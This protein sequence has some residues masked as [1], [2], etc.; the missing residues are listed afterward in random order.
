MKMLSKQK[1]TKPQEK[2]KH[3]HGQKK[4]CNTPL[5]TENFKV[6]QI[7]KNLFHLRKRGTDIIIWFN[8]IDLH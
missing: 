8:I 6:K 2:K 3:G 1:E 5:G 4:N 7:G